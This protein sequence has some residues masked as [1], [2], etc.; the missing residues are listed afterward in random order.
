M[1]F[2][3]LFIYNPIGPRKDLV[4]TITTQPIYK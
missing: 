2:V 3:M 4:T 1:L